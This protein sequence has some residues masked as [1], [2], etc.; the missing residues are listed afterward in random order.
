MEYT[1]KV[2]ALYMMAD[3][4]TLDHDTI[5]VHLIHDLIA[6]TNTYCWRTCYGSF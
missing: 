3:R 4:A 6:A 1:D 2:R 5:D